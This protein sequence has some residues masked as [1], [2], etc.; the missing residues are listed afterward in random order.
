MRGNRTLDGTPLQR[1]P[2]RT[3]ASHSGGLFSDKELEH[4]K[5]PPTSIFVQL[6]HIVTGIHNTLVPTVKRLSTILRRY[7]SHVPE[8]TQVTKRLMPRAR[9]WFMADRR[10]IIALLFVIIV[11]MYVVALA[12]RSTHRLSSTPEIPATS[13][14]THQAPATLPKGNPDFTTVLPANRS[15]DQL[16]GWTKVSPPNSAPVFAYTDKIG[17]TTIIVSQQTLPD[18]LRT[19]TANKV[20]QLAGTYGQPE[21]LSAGS[22]TVYLSRSQSG[23]ASIAFTQR[24]L[25]IF[26][27]TNDAIPDSDLITY[28]ASLR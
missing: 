22:T 24:D 2:R 23:P 8:M 20:K 26:I 15:I 7:L 28:I 10:R 14:S 27:K 13:S 4:I 9:Q 11:V 19:D 16:G 21:Q 18:E 5:K 25:L 3:P 1:A 17:S 6:R 12:N